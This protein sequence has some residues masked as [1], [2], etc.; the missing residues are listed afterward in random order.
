M[1]CIEVKRNNGMPAALEGEPAGRLAMRL[2]GRHA[3]AL[4]FAV[5]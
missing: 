3:F 1:A 4:H 2:C 5:G